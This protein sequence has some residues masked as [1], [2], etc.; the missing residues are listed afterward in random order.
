M[1]LETREFD[2]TTIID[3]GRLVS[4]VRFHWRLCSDL[5]STMVSSSQ[6]RSHINFVPAF[7]CSQD[8]KKQTA[9]RLAQEQQHD[10]GVQHNTELRDHPIRPL[11]ERQLHGYPIYHQ[12]GTFA[13][14]R[15]YH[16]HQINHHPAG[17][18]ARHAPQ[19]PYNP[20]YQPPVH[21]NPNNTG[22]SQAR[23]YFENSTVN[24]RNQPDQHQL[25][26]SSNPVCRV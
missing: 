24:Q 7:S 8:L 13:E 16:N 9:L 20:Q 10:Q 21:Q 11:N 4:W 25:G 12:P 23:Q 5:F 15:P 2:P 17:L 6:C 18:N 22:P 19:K 1:A 3:D 26:T 14:H